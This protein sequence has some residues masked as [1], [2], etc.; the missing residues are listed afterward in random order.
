M[1]KFFSLFSLFFKKTKPKA[2]ATGER[3]Q[4]RRKGKNNEK[5]REYAMQKM[6]AGMQ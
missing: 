1:T 3:E 4:R 2:I 5:T 6:S